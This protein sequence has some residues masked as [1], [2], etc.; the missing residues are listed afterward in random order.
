MVNLIG[1]YE[2]TLDSKGRMLL[3]SGLKK[4]M[5]TLL[6][7][8]FVLKRSVFQPCLE[9]HPMSEWNQVMGKINKLNRFVKKNNDFIRQFTAGLKNVEIDTSGRL[10]ISKDLIQF[11]KLEKNIVIAAAINVIEIWDKNLYEDSVNVNE[12]DFANLAEEVMGN[13]SEDELS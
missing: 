7:E 5:D 9:L 4:Q 13:I 8:G 12:L 10:Q 3:P 6:Q 2:C 11:A 1:T